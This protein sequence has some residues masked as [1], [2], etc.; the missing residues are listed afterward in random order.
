VAEY[1]FRTTW[2]VRAPRVEVFQ[3]L[4]DSERWPEWWRGVVSVEKLEQGDA[5]GVGSL[6]RYRWRSRLPY[7]VEFLTRITRVERPHLLEGRA[8]GG[9]AGVGLWR[10]FE[11]GGLTAVV[12]DWRVRTTPPWMN[13]LAPLARPLFTWNHDVVMRWG[14]EGLSSRL[15]APVSYRALEEQ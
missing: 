12:Y 1:S 10:L 6:G 3:P 5:E 9:L 7:T 11:H 14:A 4:W 2:V 13:A 15:G 8:Q